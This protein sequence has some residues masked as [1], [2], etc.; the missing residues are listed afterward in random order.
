MPAPVPEP[1]PVPEPSPGRPSVAALYRYPVKGLS[2]EPLSS[3]TL[4]PGRGVPG[5][6]IWALARPDTA[7]DE[8]DPVPL[9]KT[10][11]LALVKDAE[12]ARLR[13]SFDPATG[14]LTIVDGAETFQARIGEAAGATA[15]AGYFARLGVDSLGGAS[16]RLVAGSD[17]HRF[18]DVSVTSAE[19]MHAIS[20]INL[21][22]VRDLAA[23]TGRDVHPL[24]FR[25]NVYIDGVPPGA[26]LGWVGARLRLGAVEADVLKRTT[27]CMATAVDPSTARRDLHVPREL[28]AAY[29]HTDCGIYLA[30][31]SAGTIR[32][33]DPL[34]VPASS[35][36]P[37]QTPRR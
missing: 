27:R 20:V 29:G 28:N 26:E 24:R 31:R 7:F 2:A 36:P 5:D 33:G 1:V 35:A 21:S 23:H 8:A 14:I 19:Y 4:R 37:T 30:V 22:T 3:V 12:L 32:P 25:A 15:V 18:T 16:P 10:R 13:T 6:R 17:A 9:P 11:F 34:T